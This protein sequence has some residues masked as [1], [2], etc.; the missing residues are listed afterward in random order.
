MVLA[1]R[2]FPVL[3]AVQPLRELHLVHAPPEGRVVPQ[4]P[5]LPC[6]PEDRAFLLSLEGLVLVR[7]VVRLALARPLLRALP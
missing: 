3:L 7:Q 5:V 4:V 1:V 2:R 6:R